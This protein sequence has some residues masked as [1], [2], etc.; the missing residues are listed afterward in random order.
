MSLMKKLIDEGHDIFFSFNHGYLNKESIAFMCYLLV[1]NSLKSSNLEYLSLKHLKEIFST[2]FS[3]RSVDS[4]VK[5][6]IQLE[7]LQKLPRK[8]QQ[9]YRLQLN[10]PLL[11]FL[12]TIYY[13]D[14]QFLVGKT[15][16]QK[17]NLSKLIMFKNQLESS[18]IPLLDNDSYIT[19]TSEDLL[20]IIDPGNSVEEIKEKI[21]RE[22]MNKNSSKVVK[23]IV[24]EIKQNEMEDS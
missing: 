21:F 1:T 2:H 23:D 9:S 3:K 4:F 14:Y 17:S 11:R 18:I 6:L 7:I 24:I 10:H 8:K 13:P 22:L 15:K 12:L 19:A 5:L 16:S 20:E